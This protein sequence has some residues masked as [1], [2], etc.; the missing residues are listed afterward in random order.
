MANQITKLDGTNLDRVEQSS[1]SRNKKKIGEKSGVQ[2]EQ[3]GNRAKN[4]KYNKT[5]ENKDNLSLIH[6]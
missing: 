6:I 5:G 3:G 2:G 4:K 1:Q